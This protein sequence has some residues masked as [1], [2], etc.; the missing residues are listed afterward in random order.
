MNSDLKNVDPSLEDVLQ[1]FK[2]GSRN[3]I[4]LK[5]I[6]INGIPVQCST[7]QTH[8]SVY[9]DGKLNF[10]TNIAEKCGKTSTRIGVIKK[11]FKSYPRNALLTIY[12][13]LLEP[14]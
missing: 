3:N 6:L 10:N 12:N 14:T 11:L 7:I 4:I 5:E 2:A 1:Y 13:Y 9:L 8:L